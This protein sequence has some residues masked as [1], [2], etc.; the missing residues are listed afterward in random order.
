MSDNQRFLF[1]DLKHVRNALTHLGLFGKTTETEFPDLDAEAVWS[2]TTVNGKMKRGS[3][4][5]AG[6]GSTPR[7]VR[8][9]R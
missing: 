7:E 2:E 8:P 5:H 1:E 4:L 9:C 3:R 6:F